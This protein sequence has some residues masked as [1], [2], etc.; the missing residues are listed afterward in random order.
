MSEYSSIEKVMV[1]EITRWKRKLVHHN[2]SWILTVPKPMIEANFL[3]R[4]QKVM[5][6]FGNVIDEKSGKFFI[7]FEIVPCEGELKR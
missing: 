3:K 7:T 4:N 5:V 6:V 1:K 2:G